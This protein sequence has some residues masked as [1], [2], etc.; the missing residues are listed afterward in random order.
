MLNNSEMND[1]FVKHIRRLI[2]Y[3]LSVLF[4]NDN[5]LVYQGSEIAVSVDC[6]FLVSKIVDNLS[7]CYVNYAESGKK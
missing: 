4:E 7:V 3:N 6:K 1:F 2:S 5:T